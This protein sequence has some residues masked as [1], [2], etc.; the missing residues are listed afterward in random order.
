MLTAVVFCGTLSF[1][2]PAQAQPVCEYDRHAEDLRGI[3]FASMWA[4]TS[5]A[6]SYLEEGQYPCADKHTQVETWIAPFSTLQCF[7][8]TQHGSVCLKYNDHATQWAQV[9][10]SG[11]N[12][13]AWGPYQ[14]YSKHW[15]IIPG[16]YWVNIENPNTQGEV[17]FTTLLAGRPSQNPE[18]CEGYEFL[19][20][21]EELICDSPI[22]VPLTRAQ[23]YKLTSVKDGVMFDLNADGQLEKT[24]W[25]AADSRLAFLAIDR[26]GNGTIDNGSELFGNNTLSG[27]QN[28]F[29]ALSEMNRQLKAG[30][31]PLVP[32]ISSDE[33]LFSKL[34]L[35]EDKNHDGISQF[36]E[37]QPASDVVSEIGLGYQTHKRKDGNGNL[38][39]Y[40]G[41]AHVRTAPG[42]N[43]AIEPKELEARRIWLYD[44]FFVTER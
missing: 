33:P 13:Q 44:V 24:A 17:W 3:G 16:P 9:Y 38:F 41:F 18:E 32:F 42:R 6:V 43:R 7:G 29:E 10:P 2:S 4:N 15:Y 21:F 34:L 39:K 11:G 23:A 5:K 31:A 22:I 35:W 20:E 36:D 25:T 19:D 8:G 30:S 37:L 1:A 27:V 40:R 14:G 26:N 12:G 28:G